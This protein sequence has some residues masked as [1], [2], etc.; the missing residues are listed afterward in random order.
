MVERLG[1][2]DKQTAKQ[3]RDEYFERYHATAKALTIA[4]QEGRF[5]PSAA[6]FDYKE[7]ADYWANNLNYQLLG[8]PKTKLAQDFRDLRD[9]GIIL[10]AFSNGPRQ[11]VKRVLKELGVYE[12]F[13]EEWLFAVDD[14]LPYCKPEKEAFETVFQKIGGVKPE[15]CVMIE[16]S[17]KNVRRA[18]EI[19]L[20]TVLVTGKGRLQRNRVDGQS[21]SA[22]ADE[23]EATKAGDAPIE[24]DPA[25]DVAIETVE[26]LRSV[27]PSLWK[28]PSFFEPHNNHVDNK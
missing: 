20:K 21:S 19:G 16:D 2:P 8:G 28:T 14:V 7:L 4:Q 9:N 12:F 27:V 18:K 17:M 13:G 3:L 5:P 15:E 11:Y 23:S 1:F 26:E 22:A 24:D 10:V 25:V 6:Q